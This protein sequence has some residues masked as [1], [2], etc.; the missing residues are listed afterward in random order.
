MA[1]IKQRLDEVKKCMDYKCWHAA[2]KKIDAIYEDYCS[3]PDVEFTDADDNRMFRYLEE[4]SHKL[5]C[6]R[7]AGNILD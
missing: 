1:S 4:I 3:N 7:M 5:Y 6:E 2:D